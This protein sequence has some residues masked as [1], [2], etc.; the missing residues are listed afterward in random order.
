[1]TESPRKNLWPLATIRHE[2]Q[3]ISWGKYAHLAHESVLVN[4]LSLVALGLFRPHLLD[5]LQHHV[6]VTVE[7]LDTRE[8]LAV[9]PA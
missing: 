9:V 6:A 1:M 5:I 7:S 8:Q 2:K 3:H 4:S